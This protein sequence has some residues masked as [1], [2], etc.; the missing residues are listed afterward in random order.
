MPLRQT[1]ERTYDRHFESGGR[2]CADLTPAACER[3]G[4]NFFVQLLARLATKLGDALAS[5]RLVLSWLM[6]GIGV[7]SGII[8]LIVP[9]REAGSLLP[10]LVIGSAVRRYAVRKWFWVWGSVIQGAAVGAMAMVALSMTGRRAGWALVGLTAVFA[11][12]RGV[13]SVTSKDLLGRTVPRGR[14]GR[15]TGLSASAAGL[16]TVLFG[17][18]LIYTRPE[19]LSVGVFAAILGV[20]GVLWLAA[21]LLMSRLDEVP[22]RPER[23]GNTMRLAVD[24][25]WLL[26]RDRNFLRFVISRGL[27]AGTVLSMPFFVLLAR[28]ATRSG[29]ATFG[30]FLIAGSLATAASGFVWGRLADRSSRW[31]IT[32]AG[33][34]AAGVGFGAWA[35]GG[36]AVAGSGW[37]GVDAAGWAWAG[38]FCAL[39]LAHTGIRVGR[40]TY[41]VDS[42]PAQERAAYVAVSN[43]IIGVVVLAAGSI[44]VLGDIL[45]ARAVI[46]VFAALGLAGAAL[47]LSLRE[48]E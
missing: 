23:D 16:A 17:G 14:R 22:T 40:K 1:V 2:D 3:A 32:L 12:A 41:L 31:T 33:A 30:L 34:G 29:A 38:M 15:L 25:L 19:T 21:G 47:S 11:L 4:W 27:L 10:Q 42:A 44:G 7:S 28:D 39:S 6:A 48:V 45:S 13:C 37:L 20:A 26:R 9:L 24:S 18:A 43:T 46:A 5:P 35:L 36:V 8:G